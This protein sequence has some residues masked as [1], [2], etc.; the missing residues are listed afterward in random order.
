MMADYDGRLKQGE[1]H[2]VQEINLSDYFYI[3]NCNTITKNHV[4]IKNV[5]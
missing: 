4:P 3:E 2:I 1:E 5:F